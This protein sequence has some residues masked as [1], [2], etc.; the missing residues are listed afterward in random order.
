MTIPIPLGV[1]IY[2]PPLSLDVWVTK[3]VEGLT[4]R[5]A[6]PGGFIDATI[7]FRRFTPI[8]QPD[9][10]IWNPTTSAVSTDNQS[11][12]VTDANAAAIALGD[13]FWVYN[14]GGTIRM[15]GDRFTVTAKLSSGGTTTVSYAPSSGSNL[16]ASGDSVVCRKPAAF[17]DSSITGFNRMVNLFNRI[18][19][20]DLRT[21]EIAWE[22]RIEDPARE[23]DKDTWTLGCLGNTVFATD[24]TRP[25]YYLDNDTDSWLIS[26]QGLSGYSM[27]NDQQ[28]NIIRVKFTEGWPYDG[29]ASFADFLRR[30]FIFQ[31]PERT[32]M[33]GIGRFDGIANGNDSDVTAPTTGGTPTGK[34]GI[35]LQAKK[36]DD[37][38]PTSPTNQKNIAQYLLNGA[39][40]FHF[41]KV[42]GT[43]ITD[44]AKQLFL[45]AG[46]CSTNTT[47]EVEGGKDTW[48]TWTLPRVQCERMDRY[49][50]MLNTGASYPDGAL[51]VAPVVE[52]VVGRFLNNG[53]DRNNFDLPYQ[54]HVTPFNTYIDTSS[55]ILMVDGWSFYE[56]ITA[57]EILQKLIDEAAPNAFWGLWESNF[58]AT[59]DGFQ[60]KARFAWE[61]WPNSWGYQVTTADGFTEQ[62][63]GEEEYNYVWYIYGNGYN[64]GAG[65]QWTQGSRHVQ[66]YWTPTSTQS[67]ATDLD[68]NSVTRAQ[69]VVRGST[70]DVYAGSGVFAEAGQWIIDNSHTTNT[71]QIKIGRPVLVYDN[72]ASGPFG[73]A[74]NLDPWMVRSGKLCRIIDV[75]PKNAMNDFAHGSSLPNRGFE[76]CIFRM[77]SVEYDSDANMATVDLDE[78]PKWYVPQQIVT[79]TKPGKSFITAYR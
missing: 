64:E 35:T 51:K 11:F 15:N 24:I 68:L 27:E 55:S 63:S 9:Q 47:V 16:V 66:T 2:S 13:R 59:D 54:G 57:K 52:D 26:G 6:V 23:T 20:V 78:P 70:T 32:D 25:I 18:Q 43:H 1:R 50:T 77:V 67:L 40:D 29:N 12:K 30:L 58:G 22:G 71:G 31:G 5:N 75:H 79:K 28:N 36:W 21:A 8:E 45:A 39:A 76:T 49:G 14:S 56:G 38:Y 69:T 7:R 19:V 53:W 65:N 61:L 4:Y 10:L 62:P 48:G 17:Y 34:L 33:E 44:G 3:N 60:G 37:T 41:N 73:I 46:Y 74:R 72:G 42:V